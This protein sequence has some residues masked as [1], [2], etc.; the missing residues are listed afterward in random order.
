MVINRLLSRCPHA[1]RRIAEFHPVLDF[2]MEKE[3]IVVAMLKAAWYV[4]IEAENVKWRDA[5]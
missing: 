4:W 2:R 1:K 5:I 3:L